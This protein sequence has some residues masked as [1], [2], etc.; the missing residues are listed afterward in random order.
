M[1]YFTE[2]FGISFQLACLQEQRMLLLP[3]RW[4]LS[5]Y[6]IYC[7]CRM[8]GSSEIFFI[9]VFFFNFLESHTFPMK[10]VDMIVNAC[11]GFLPSFG[12]APRNYWQVVWRRSVF[13][14]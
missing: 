9:K 8:S 12:A 4:Y 2:Y 5:N 6:V 1:E 14:L 13:D 11:P 3:A 10:I 7:L